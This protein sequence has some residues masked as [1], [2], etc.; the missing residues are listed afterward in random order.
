MEEKLENIYNFVQISDRVA[1]AGQ[2][3]EIQYPTIAAAG[4]QTVINL[5]LTD[6]CKCATG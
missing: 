4:Y 1:T 6:I 2:P 5:A 3:T